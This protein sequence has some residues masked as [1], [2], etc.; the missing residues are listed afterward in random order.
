MIKARLGLNQA[1]TIQARKSFL[2]AR[3]FAEKETAQGL[4]TRTTWDIT[5]RTR[6]SKIFISRLP[7]PSLRIVQTRK[8]TMAAHAQPKYLTGD[9][10]AINEF[11]DKFDVRT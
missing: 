10:A 7:S 3:G 6:L 2:R 4:G 5:K 9:K 1:H 8:L 11:I